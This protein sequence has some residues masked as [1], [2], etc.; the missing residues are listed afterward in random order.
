MEVTIS[1]PV[2]NVESYIEQSLLSA[3]NQQFDQPYEVLVIDDGSTDR[4]MLLVE[5]IRQSHRRGERVRI[6]QMPQHNGPGDT[7][8]VSIERCQGKYLLF[9]DA[10]D[11]LADDALAILYELA[12]QHLADVV[13]GST[14][15]VRG[16]TVS[17]GYHLEPQ[18]I[19]QPAA[20]VYLHAHGSLLNIEMWNK[21][22]RTDFLR[23]HQLRC[24]HPVIEDS[25]FDF[26]MR[27]AAQSLVLTDRVTY[28]Y[29]QRPD[30]VMGQQL[31]HP[32]S[33]QLIDIHCDIIRQTQQLVSQR[34]ANVAGIY[35]LYCLRLAY[36]WYTLSRTQLTSAQEQQVDACMI[37]SLQF[38]PHMRSLQQGIYR[39]AYLYCRLRH[40]DWHRF[41][42]I[43]NQRYTRWHRLMAFCL[44]Y[45]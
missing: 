11:R 16:Q 21:L 10:D 22:F 37:Q 38:I 35:D 4:S 43:Y 31:G 17:H 12:E 29:T 27:I 2:Y 41:G 14:D 45:L 13:A 36:L 26:E 19:C 32:I 44:S 5:Q 40:K 3:L 28:Y 34:Y 25:L 6:I 39:Y 15:E 8:N 9:L 7:R 18:V 24:V 30:S 23:Q 42:Y 1:I 33:D 20:G